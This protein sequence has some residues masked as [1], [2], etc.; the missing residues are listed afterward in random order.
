M[1]SLWLTFKKYFQLGFG[2]TFA[3]ATIAFAVRIIED[4]INVYSALFFGIIG[5]P[6]LIAGAVKLIEDRKQYSGE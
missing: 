4:P 1:K 6:L 3:L 5:F 2:I